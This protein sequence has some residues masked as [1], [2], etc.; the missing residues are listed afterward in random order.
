MDKDS[1]SLTDLTPLFQICFRIYSYFYLNIQEQNKIK[2]FIVIQKKNS[3]PRQYE[4]KQA[5]LVSDLQCTI[6]LA[7]VTQFF[8]HSINPSIQFVFRF[9]NPYH[10]RV[11]QKI[12]SLH[13]PIW[14]PS[15]K[16]VT[17]PMVEQ[18]PLT[19]RLCPCYP[20]AGQGPTG[21]HAVLNTIP[22]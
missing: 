14:I 16:F 3:T 22:T 7:K 19:Q 13:S 9:L 10:G 12:G 5:H 6:S 1:C 8:Q 15:V 17:P 20:E 18:V 11:K 21:L 2:L 4:A